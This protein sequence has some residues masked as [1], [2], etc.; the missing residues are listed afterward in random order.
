MS[1]PAES[2]VGPDAII[3]LPLTNGCGESPFWSAADEA[4]FWVDIPAGKIHRWSLADRTSASWQ[5]PEQV[6]CIARQR[7]G[8]MLAACESGIYSTSLQL[9]QQNV[10][11]QAGIEHPAP[12]MRFNDGRCD[13]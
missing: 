10:V 5:L 1:K 12:S 7:N 2:T 9:P 3:A 11:R 8:D 6:G 4:F 13:R